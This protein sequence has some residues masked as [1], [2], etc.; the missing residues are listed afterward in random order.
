MREIIWSIFQQPAKPADAGPDELSDPEAHRMA[1][2]AGGAAIEGRAA[3]GVVLSDVR[4]EA[5]FAQRPH[6]LGGVAL[7]GPEGLALPPGQRAGHP[8]DG[9]LCCLTKLGG[10]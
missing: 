9:I 7:V 6:T 10:G 8:S 4:G 5:D 2:M 1:R 3:V